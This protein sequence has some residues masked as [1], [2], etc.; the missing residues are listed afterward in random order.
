[1]VLLDAEETLARFMVRD[2]PDWDRFKAAMEAT[3]E[4]LKERTGNKGVRAYGEMVDLLWNAGQSDAA[5]Q[6]EQFWNRLLAA[7]GFSL[8][9]AYQI[10]VF[11]K[12]FHGSVLDA[13]LCTHTHVLPTGPELEAAVE[14]AVRDVL[15]CT[16]ESLHQ[17]APDARRPA[18]GIIPPGEAKVL[19]IRN[20]L[21]SYADEILAR[22]RGYMKQGTGEMITRSS[23]PP[24]DSSQPVRARPSPDNRCPG[25]PAADPRPAPLPDATPASQAARR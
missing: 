10:D 9:C 2:L 17:R 14:R 13:V 7:H 19:W 22:A 4:P 8:H 16:L 24:P 20:N 25:T 18:W 23:S 11:G 3:L 15:G 21:P 1:M 6:L 5:A 12:E